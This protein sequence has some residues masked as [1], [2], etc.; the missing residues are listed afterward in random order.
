MADSSLPI[1]RKGDSGS[2]VALLQTFL[3]IKGFGT[4]TNP[5]LQLRVDGV[6]GDLTDSVVRQFQQSASLKVDGIV[7]AKTWEAFVS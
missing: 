1:L 5:N 4:S 6:F 2:T 3:R 7:G